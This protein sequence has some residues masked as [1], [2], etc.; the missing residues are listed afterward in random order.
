VKLDH[1]LSD[2]L[3]INGC[4]L[5]D[6]VS[7]GFPLSLR[8]GLY[9]SNS[10]KIVL[11]SE[12]FLVLGDISPLVPGHSLMLTKNHYCS[13]GQVPGSMLS[14]FLSLREQSISCLAS[15][16]AAPLLFEHGSSTTAP[17]GG[18]CIEHAH[19]HLLPVDA[20]VEEWL[21]EVGKVTPGSVMGRK[22]AL[23]ENY[24]WCRKQDGSEYYV[25]DFDQAIPSQFIRQALA[26]HFNIPEWNWKSVLTRFPL[27]P[28]EGAP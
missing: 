5:C 21:A 6:E 25:T 11:Q 10:E 26:D 12:H 15:N 2:S 8:L 4:L 3:S 23:S 16:Y 13:F 9:S 28:R 27:T 22:P 18:A 20:P 19:I 1:R 24:L 17:G 14:E 7:G